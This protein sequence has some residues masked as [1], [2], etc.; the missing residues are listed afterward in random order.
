MWATAQAQPNIALI[1]YW[2]KK[3]LEK[4]LPAVGSLSITLDSLWTR[5]AVDL[6]GESEQDSLRVNSQD[7]RQMLP[8]VARCLDGVVGEGRG[9]AAVRSESNFPIG[10]GLA[11]SASAFAA[12]VVAAESAAGGSRAAPS[13]RIIDRKLCHTTPRGDIDDASRKPAGLR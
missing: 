2:G 1:K 11:S 7:N 8:R 4:N 3:D 10:A 13:L 6:S 9:P 5:M 12:L